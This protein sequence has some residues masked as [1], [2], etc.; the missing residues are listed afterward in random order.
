MD[1]LYNDVNIYCGTDKD[2]VLSVSMIELIRSEM[3][4]KLFQSLNICDGCRDPVSVIIA[5]ELEDVFSAA[6]S[7]LSRKSGVSIIQGLKI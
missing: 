1:N 7:K 2:P 3:F 4:L 6:F 5:G